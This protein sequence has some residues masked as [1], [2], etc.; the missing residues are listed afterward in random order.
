MCCCVKKRI[1]CTGT[2]YTALVFH[3]LPQPHLLSGSIIIKSA[4]NVIKL[5]SLILT[6]YPTLLHA[7][8][9]TSFSI[10]KRTRSWRTRF[11]TRH[12]LR[13]AKHCYSVVKVHARPMPDLDKTLGL[14]SALKTHKNTRYCYEP[15]YYD[16]AFYETDK[17]ATE[18]KTSARS[19]I[20]Q[21]L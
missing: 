13:Y 16:Y 10:Y 15:L 7:Q 20:N 14:L 6:G 5:P 11:A 18:N 12:S 21:L 1:L 17:T 8:N 2:G 9:E 4:V 19:K 3:Q